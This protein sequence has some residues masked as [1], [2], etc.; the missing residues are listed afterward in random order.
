[1]HPT[2]IPAL[3]ADLAA[4]RVLPP[5]EA[6]AYVSLSPYTLER[7]RLSDDPAGP[8]WVRLS[9]RRVG[10]RLADLDAWLEARITRPAAADE[11]A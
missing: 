5:R 4:R 3:P 7:M 2:A 8:P 11:A 9:E 6:A 1:M 10:Y